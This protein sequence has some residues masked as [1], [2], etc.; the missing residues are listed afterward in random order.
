[1]HIFNRAVV[2]GQ[3]RGI[4]D[5]VGSIEENCFCLIVRQG[6]IY[7]LK[8]LCY[9]ID[10]QLERVECILGSAHARNDNNVIREG[11]RLNTLGKARQ[12]VIYIHKEAKRREH[13]TLTDASVR[14]TKKRGVIVVEFKGFVTEK[15][16]YEV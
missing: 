1:M 8:F 9:L 7:G 2:N 14:K 4:Y 16:G 13:A 15:A 10:C 6:Q 11:Q 12:N 5:F 3:R